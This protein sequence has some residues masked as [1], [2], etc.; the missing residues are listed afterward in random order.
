V[1]LFVVELLW[2]LVGGISGFKL[3]A[4]VAGHVQR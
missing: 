3:A 4:F 2:I 1:A